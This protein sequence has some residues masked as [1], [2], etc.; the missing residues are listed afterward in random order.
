[1]CFGRPDG[2]RAPEHE[3]WFPGGLPED[4]SACGVAGICRGGIVGVFH[5]PG[6]ATPRLAQGQKQRDEL[7]GTTDRRMPCAGQSYR[8]PNVAEAAPAPWSN[9]TRAA[10]CCSPLARWHIRLKAAWR[11]SARMSTIRGY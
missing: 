4:L 2:V 6:S 7:V 1:C 9:A 8:F 3:I 11:G 5:R 10:A